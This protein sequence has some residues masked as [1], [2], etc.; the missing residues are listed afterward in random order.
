MG[1]RKLAKILLLA[2][3]QWVEVQAVSLDKHEAL[4]SAAQTLGFN[5]PP[6]S[7]AVTPPTTGSAEALE[8]HALSFGLIATPDASPSSEHYPISSPFGEV[9]LPSL[10]ATTRPLK[11]AI[12][13]HTPEHSPHRKSLSAH[14]KEFLLVDDNLINL[15]MLSTYMKKLG[16]K[17][18]TA[19]DGQQAVNKYSK[20]P[21]LYRC[22]F[23]DIS[24][25]IMNGFEATRRIRA[26]EKE[27]DLEPSV[28]VALSGLASAEAQQEAFGCGIDLFLTKPVKLTELGTILR[29]RGLL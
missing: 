2:F 23:M 9:P 7:S 10:R 6:H 16:R 3:N 15:Q 28:I 17:Y 24:M 5:I 13:S 1:P 25:P 4:L 29:S 26:F 11:A 20:S 21:E 19:T 8:R 14:D 22:I 12:L 27:R 18:N